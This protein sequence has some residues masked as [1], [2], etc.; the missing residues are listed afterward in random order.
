MSTLE[1]INQELNIPSLNDWKQALLSE[2]K[3]TEV[4]S[5]LLKN[6]IEGQFSILSF[7]GVGQVV[8][9]QTAWKKS[10]QT[11]FSPSTD[12]LHFLDEDLANG[13]RAFFFHSDLFSKT[14]LVNCLKKIES[15]NDAKHVDVVLLG[16]SPVEL[17]SNL[18]IIQVSAGVQAQEIF[19]Q[20]GTHLQELGQLTLKVVEW[21]E[22][23][24]KA[25]EL[26]VV[27]STDNHYFQ[28]IAKLRALKEI[29][30]KIFLEYKRNLKLNLI[31]LVNTRDWTLYE[32]YNNVLRNA[33]AVS[34]G[35]IGGADLVQS[36]SYM[37]TF[38]NETSNKENEHIE[39]SRRLARNTTHILSLESMLGMVQDA[40]AG[41]YHL[42][43]LTNFY[44]EAAWKLMQSL[45]SKT[46]DDRFHFWKEELNKV[47]QERLKQ[48]NL[49]KL[50]ISGVNDY[51][52]VKEIL[53]LE[54]KAP[55]TFRLSR[56]FENLRLKT[57]KLKKKPQVRIIFWGD[58]AALNG[59]LNF[60]KNYF[61][62]LGLTVLEP[63][64]SV[65]QDKDLNAWLNQLQ[66]N[67]ILVLCAKDEDYEMLAK[68][69][70][71]SPIANFV[72]G[73]V[74]IEHFTSLFVGQNVYDVLQTLV[75]ELES[76]V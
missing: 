15:H 73:K 57:E 58:Y 1:T 19:E 52:N 43:T 3:L 4:D 29:T 37:A 68:K 75:Q 18:K 76:K 61:E 25:T 40:A 67:E 69:V 59:R 9:T 72:A 60:T 11:Y 46:E 38:E 65:T 56:H 30:T 7:E 21:C 32:R 31:T 2:L 36:L 50:V 14:H 64:H 53:S 24:P 33:I 10:S 54:L 49:R 16:K 70:K 34:A 5:K 44:A 66:N 63:H 74:Q 51:P 39:R 42:E 27:V 71:L 62:L 47:Q 13:V 17:K 48:F 23:N 28:S 55:T 45:I 41:S 22:K 6:T 12:D 20:G 26:T 8:P 35:L